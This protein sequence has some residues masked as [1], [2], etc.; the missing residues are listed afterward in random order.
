[1]A[2]LFIYTGL[3]ACPA[4]PGLIYNGRMSLAERIAQDM[5]TALKARQ[6][7]RLSTLRMAKT[8]IKNREIEKRHALEDAETMQVLGTLIKQREDAAAQFAQGNRPELAEK[9]K[10]EIVILN[11]YLPQML[12]AAEVEAAVVAAIAATGAASAKDM[13]GV[14]KAVMAQFQAG[15]GRADGKLVSETV[16]RK[17]SGG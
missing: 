6:E 4:L 16:K 1:M 3:A 8:A 5:V 11:E 14:M 13:G 2:A 9:E 17:L 7:L 15:G 10:A 12:S